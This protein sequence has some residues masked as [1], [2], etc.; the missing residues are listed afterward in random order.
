M[1][2]A[3]LYVQL[4]DADR[5]GTFQ[6]RLKLAGDRPVYPTIEV[7][8]LRG[9]KAIFRSVKVATTWTTN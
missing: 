9:N 3:K 4:G 2:C 8:N 6:H 1:P 5:S 7:H